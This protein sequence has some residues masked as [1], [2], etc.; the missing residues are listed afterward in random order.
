MLLFNGRG[1]LAFV[2]SFAAAEGLMAALQWS[3]EGRMMMLAGPLLALFDLAYRL[4]RA[5]TFLRGGPTILFLPAWIWGLLWTGLGA[6]Y[7]FGG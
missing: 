5:V 4:A 3:G 6:W 2:L 7:T 1:L